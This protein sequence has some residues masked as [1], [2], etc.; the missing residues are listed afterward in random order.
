M[1]SW[2]SADV[3]VLCDLAQETLS[4][5]QEAYATLR[6]GAR[7]LRRERNRRFATKLNGAT[8][9]IVQFVS[10]IAPGGYSCLAF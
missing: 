8:T 2:R 9:G 4:D 7:A 3:I 6:R 10:R 1:T 5:F